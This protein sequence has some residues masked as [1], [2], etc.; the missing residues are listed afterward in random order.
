MT[1]TT[2]RLEK[3]LAMMLVKSME[4]ANQA[5]RAFALSAC[6]FSNAD[7]A[8]MLGTTQGTINQLLYERRKGKKKPAGKKVAAKKAKS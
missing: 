5:D 4:D 8:E 2:E 7:I 3:I 1:D 6:G